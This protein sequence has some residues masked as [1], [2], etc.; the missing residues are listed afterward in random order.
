LHSQ[1]TAE[2]LRAMLRPDYPIGCK[3]VLISSAWYPTMNRAK[4]EV[5]GALLGG[6]RT[7]SVVGVDG[8]ER[9]VDAI[10]SE[11]VSQVGCDSWYVTDAGKNTNDWPGFT[12]D[13]RRQTRYFDPVHYVT[14]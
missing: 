4:V 5:I 9:A 3:R 11:P 12:F 7:D 13:Y 1:I 10:I 14:D 6:V 8:S 2:E